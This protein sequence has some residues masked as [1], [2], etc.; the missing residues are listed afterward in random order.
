FIAN[1]LRILLIGKTGVGKSALGNVIIGR[2][3]FES[4]P[5][6]DSVTTK[7]QSYRCER[8]GRTILVVDTPGLFDTKHSKDEILTEIAKCYG[9]TS[10]GP[11][12][13]LMVRRPDRF[14]DEEKET[15]EIL[16]KY[17]GNDLFKYMIMVYT[18]K[19]EINREETEKYM[20]NKE[21][22]GN[23]GSEHAQLLYSVFKMTRERML[24]LNISDEGFRDEKH[25]RSLLGMID[26]LVD[27][28][29]GKFFQNFNYQCVEKVVQS[30]MNVKNKDKDDNS[31][32]AN[33][34]E[35]A[36]D[37]KSHVQGGTE[38]TDVAQRH[39]EQPTAKQ[40]I[41]RRQVRD[42]IENEK[43]GILSKIK[44]I[45]KHFRDWILSLSDDNE[46]KHDPSSF[47]HSQVKA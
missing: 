34:T 12:S 23:R 40:T 39:T 16:H 2:K 25:V 31:R 15:V 35:V 24:P 5:S 42:D 46:M 20:I 11:H 44:K 17:F 28:N 33:D 38:S 41:S 14:T 3:E 37:E 8:F 18:Y 10:P 7:C 21:K 4:E 43:Q 13:V 27:Q 6:P 30:H 1:E 36:C 26:N 32:T 45:L 9:L 29:G 19:G 22:R 47:F